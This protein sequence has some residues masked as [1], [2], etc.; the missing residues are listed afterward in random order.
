MD[1]PWGP[2]NRFS[3]PVDL[4]HTSPGREASQKKSRESPLECEYSMTFMNFYRDPLPF[5]ENSRPVLLPN[6]LN[7]LSTTAP[8]LNYLSPLKVF[9]NLDEN[10]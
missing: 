8:D 6:H 4:P 7:H 1:G 2:R 5:S 3:Q 9:L 10:R